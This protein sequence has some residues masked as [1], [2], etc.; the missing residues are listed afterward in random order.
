M[1]SS[2]MHSGPIKSACPIICWLI[3]SSISVK[4]LLALN[5]LPVMI[6]GEAYEYLIKKFADDSGH[7]AAEF[8]TNRTVVHLM[9][10]IMGLKHG[11]TAYDQHAALAGCC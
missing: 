11:E 9:T 5:L 1:A 7:T 3:L 2:V 10:R 8:Y 4:F 6:L